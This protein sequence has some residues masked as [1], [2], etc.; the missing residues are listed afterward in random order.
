MPSV[1]IFGAGLSKRTKNQ[2]EVFLHKVFLRPPRVMDVRAFGSRTSVQKTIFSCAPS[3]G[4]KF[5]GQDV[6]LDIRREARGG[7]KTLCL[8]FFSLPDITRLTCVPGLSAG[9]FPV[10]HCPPKHRKINSKWPPEMFFVRS[11]RSSSVI[12]FF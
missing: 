1:K 6:R 10:L 4:V 8:R 3:D 7:Q 12:L 9:S 5:F 11:C 2:P